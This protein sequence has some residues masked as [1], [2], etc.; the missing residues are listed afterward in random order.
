M[1]KEP[2]LLHI[3]TAT[4][5]CSVALS[6]GPAILGVEESADGN[7]HSKNLLPFIERLMAGTA[8]RIEEIDGVVVSIGPGSY[9][10]LRIGTSTAK[11][12]AYS[13]GK[14]VITVGTLESIAYGAAESWA[15]DGLPA[16]QYVA[17]ID[18]RRMEV[19]AGHYD[20]HLQEV[21]TPAAVIVDE[22][23]FRAMLDEHRIV[24][25]GNGMP[26]CKELL[27]PHPNA[28]FVEQPLSARSLLKPAL[29]KWEAQAF[30][31]TAYFEPFYL[32]EY[33]AAKPVVK[34][35]HPNT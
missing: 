10:G 13:L 8:H 7:S 18:A 27:S 24:F 3:E 22:N 35:L 31:D 11:G 34:G 16:P 29:K 14:P 33:V 9:T 26:K 4:E 5:V 25:C 15:D 21:D 28:L 20:E 12:I 30:A 32:K 1:T 6:K 2:L 19:F 23:A 17:M